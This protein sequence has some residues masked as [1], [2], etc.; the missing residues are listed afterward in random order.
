MCSHST[1]VASP[2]DADDA[3]TAS[4]DRCALW[5]TEVEV[6]LRFYHRLA[7]MDPVQ[8]RQFFD[9]SLRE[10]ALPLGRRE[11]LGHLRMPF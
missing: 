11:D 6:A 1:Y 10:P 7:H 9:D 3:R 2:Q 4:D 8:V 5:R